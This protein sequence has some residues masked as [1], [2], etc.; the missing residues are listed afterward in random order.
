MTAPTWLIAITGSGEF[1]DVHAQ[2]TGEP[3]QDAVAVDAALAALDLGQHDS[4][5][6]TSPASTACAKPR[7]RLARAIRWPVA[8]WSEELMRHRP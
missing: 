6:P 2:N 1:L 7:R 5:L 4:D 3:H 8:S